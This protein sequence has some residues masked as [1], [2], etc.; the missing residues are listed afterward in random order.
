MALLQSQRIRLAVTVRFIALL[1][2]VGVFFLPLVSMILTS[3]KS[4]EE[5]FRYPPVLLPEKP[6]WGNYLTAWTSVRF[7]HFLVNSV[8]LSLF[9]TL[10]CIISS[11]F[12]GYAFSRFRVK[13]RNTMFMLMLST[14][15]IPQMV[16]IIPFYILVSK[17]GLADKQWLWIVFGMQGMPFLIFL[18]KQYFSTIPISFEES[19]RLDGAGRFRIFFEIMFPLVQTAVVVAVIFAFQWSW[20]DYLQPI[21]FL[22]GEKANLAVKLAVGYT[23]QKENVLHNLYMSGLVYYTLPIVVLFFALQKRFISGLLAGGLKG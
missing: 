4:M 21:L 14:M 8:I 18:F 11:C 7:G 13:G 16:T 12:A 1:L 5:L 6:L 17:V 19:A 15:M 3:L 23:D 10:P 20:A 2:V 22:R 9:Y